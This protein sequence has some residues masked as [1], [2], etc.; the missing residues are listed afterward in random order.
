MHPVEF[1]SDGIQALPPQVVQFEI[2]RQQQ[3]LSVVADVRLVAQG[4]IAARNALLVQGLRRLLGQVGEDAR[5]LVRA[6]AAEALDEGARGLVPHARGGVAVGAQ[7][8]RPRRNDHRPG[9]HE[10]AQRVGV[11]GAGAAEGDQCE[12]AR[13]VALFHRN[14]PQRAVH[15]LVHEAYDARGRLHQRKPQGVGDLLHGGFGRAAVQLHVAAQAN[16]RRKVAEH[17]VGVRNRGLLASL[18]VGRRPRIGAGALRADAQRARELGH[19]GDGTAAGAH[20]AHVHRG[21][22]HGHVPHGGLAPQLRLTVLHQ[23]HVRGRAAHVEG[24]QVVVLGLR[25]NPDGAGNAA[26][27]AAHQQVDRVGLGRVRRGQAAVGA[28]HVQ[29]HAAHRVVELLLEIAHVGRHLRAHVGIGDRGDRALVFLH[30]RDH[31]R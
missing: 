5:R 17:H 12:L 23:R 7:H 18:G 11:Q 13:V 22:A 19:V 29:L 21:S 16:L 1:A 9:T 30:L 15:V 26:G 8:A 25:G 31:F 3:S 2:D 10:L 6:S 28:Q 24:Q 27:R 20:G 4:L 14:Q